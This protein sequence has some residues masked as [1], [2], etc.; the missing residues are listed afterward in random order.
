MINESKIP[1]YTQKD[2]QMILQISQTTLYR[3]I[4]DNGLLTPNVKR[5][6]T[7]QEIEELGT[8][9]LKQYGKKWQK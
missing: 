9:M 6:F 8:L 2:V 3:L 1:K 5:R 4:K 7:E